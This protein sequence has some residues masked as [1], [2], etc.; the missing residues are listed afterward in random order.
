MIRE[1]FKVLDTRGAVEQKS[2]SP[3]EFV[4]FSEPRGVVASSDLL[5][6]LGDSSAAVDGYGACSWVYACVSKLAQLVSS[7][8]WT[9]QARASERDEWEV[10]DDDPLARLLEFP[11]PRMSRK[12]FMQFQALLLLLKGNALSHLVA[13]ENGESPEL[14]PL[15]PAQYDPIADATGWIYGYRSRETRKDVL[16]EEVAHAMLPDPSNP[17]WGIAPLKPLADVVA[18]DIDAVK[19]NRAQ[20]KNQGVPAGVFADPNIST[21]EA[22]AEANAR[23]SAR[24]GASGARKPLVIGGGATWQSMSQTPVEMDW[25][26]SQKFAVTRIT[27]AYGLL[28]ALFAPEAATYSN[29]QIAVE[30]AWNN[31]AVPLL[32]SFEDSFNLLLIPR[33]ERGV[34]C[35]K[36]DLSDVPALQAKL[37]DKAAPFAQFVANGVPINAAAAML[38]LPLQSIAGGDD[39]LVSSSLVKLSEVGAP[40]VGGSAD[41]GVI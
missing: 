18:A 21:D 37:A 38:E 6:S 27:A 5:A 24:F 34:R 41:G 1:L 3:R 19:W 28:P 11:N 7:V 2:A 8:P 36:Y 23:I 9:I 16:A 33:R 10:R 31:G 29:L 20:L 25:L 14:W 35:V 17:L 15:N 4:R 22:L 32:D 40:D 30:W 12:A 39:P 13:G 26:E